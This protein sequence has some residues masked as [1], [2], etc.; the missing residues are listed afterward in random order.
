MREKT[1][2]RRLSI[3]IL[4]GLLLQYFKPTTPS[5]FEEALFYAGG[6]TVANFVTTMFANH[7]L[8][9]SEYLGGRIRIAVCS[10]VY[11]K[12]YIYIYIYIYT[13]G[14]LIKH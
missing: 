4:L 14:F 1:L 3:P 11:R 5:T 6:F 2:L 10:L 7:L 9:Q 13:A 8:F 12:V